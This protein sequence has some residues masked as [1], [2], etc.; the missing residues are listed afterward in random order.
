[1]GRASIPAT[2]FLPLLL[3][4]SRPAAALSPLGRC[5]A[6][7]LRG[8]DAVVAAASVLGESNRQEEEP[9]ALS[10]GGCCLANAAR[11]LDLA[12]AALFGERDWELTVGPLS[13]GA[14]CLE[15]AAAHLPGGAAE[16]L[17]AAAE[18]CE[19][20][21]SVTGCLSLAA[22]AGP[23]L[24]D[25]GGALVELGAYFDDYSASMATGATAAHAEAGRKLGEAAGAVGDAGRALRE[26]GETLQG[27]VRS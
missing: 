21:S 8:A 24:V 14:C 12:D 22:A 25:A 11:S 15:Q 27:G 3:Q 7:L 26:V 18:Q 6:S 23:N 20:A 9:G 16:P 19:E 17:L 2:V 13:D 4:L 10:A 5:A 1:M